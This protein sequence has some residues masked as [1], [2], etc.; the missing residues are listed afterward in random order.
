MYSAAFVSTWLFFKEKPHGPPLA[1][2][3]LYEKC[4][5]VYAR[6]ALEHRALAIKRERVAIFGDHR[7]DDDLIGDQR[8]RQDAL[9]HR[10]DR[11]ASLLAPFAGAFFALHH[12]Y[13]IFG[14]LHI[15]HF[16]LC[17]TDHR[18]LFAA[19]AAHALAGIAGN[20]LFDAHQVGGQ[21]LAARMFLFGLLLRVLIFGFI[22][23]CGERLAF[24]LGL[25]FFV[26]YSGL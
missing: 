22:R 24:A 4:S 18:S 25:H 21:C 8:L 12:A 10:S 16:A 26:A 9:G 17:I 3:H 19:A 11:Y 1:P 15:E 14:R 23:R 7:V 5:N 20:Y 13:E 6:I 2:L